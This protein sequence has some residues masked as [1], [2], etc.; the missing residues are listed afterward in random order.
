MV[1]LRSG[2]IAVLDTRTGETTAR[3]TAHEDAVSALAFLADGR[4]LSG[5]ADGRLL[6]WN[7]AP[8]D[9]PDEL[10]LRCTRGS[11]LASN[12][13][14]V[15]A[16]AVDPSGYLFAVS[17]GTNSVQ[18]WDA[19]AGFPVGQSEPMVLHNDTVVGM[20]FSSDGSTLVLAGSD[21]RVVVIDM[22]FETWQEQACRFVDRVFTSEEWAAYGTQEAFPVLCPP[23][24]EDN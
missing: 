17:S 10:V 11:N 8:E 3:R 2:D 16:I 12:R 7:A 18:L 9:E 20:A 5:G 14:G 1:G 22:R 24:S 4:L 23:V 21:H 15:H 6:L 13:C 19:S